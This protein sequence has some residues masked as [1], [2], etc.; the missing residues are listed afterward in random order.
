[1]NDISQSIPLGS[2]I[3][4]DLGLYRHYAIAGSSP[5]G[6]TAIAPTS[7]AGQ[8]IEEPLISLIAR[9][10]DF[11]VEPLWGFFDG[12]AVVARARSLL[13]HP[14]HV[15]AANCEHF[16]RLVHGLPPKSPQV[17]AWIGFGALAMM[18]LLALS[19]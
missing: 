1:M 6:A 7:S 13:G 2:I 4:V 18:L 5:F 14:Y 12:A 10:R 15:L 3:S 9:G 19:R 8:V 17:L 11:R 16:V